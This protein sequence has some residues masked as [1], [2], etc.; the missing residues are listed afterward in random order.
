MSEFPKSLS[1]IGL[2]AILWPSIISTVWAKIRIAYRTIVY[3]LMAL[4]FQTIC[5]N[6]LDRF[7]QPTR[8]SA[9]GS[10]HEHCYLG[11]GQAGL[12]SLPTSAFVAHLQLGYNQKPRY[13]Q[14]LRK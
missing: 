8:A 10:A 3:A 7:C 1:R 14:I 13:L 2:R 11:F 6:L 4:L 12:A 9:Y 5:K